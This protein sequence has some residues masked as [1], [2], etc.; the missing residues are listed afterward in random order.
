MSTVTH[1]IERA[2]IHVRCTCADSQDPQDCQG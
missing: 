1:P 2:S